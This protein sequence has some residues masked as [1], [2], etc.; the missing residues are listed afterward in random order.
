MNASV[1]LAA[2]VANII[3]T[4]WA[5][6]RTMKNQHKLDAFSSKLRW[7][8]VFF[9]CAIL[10]GALHFLGDGFWGLY[11]GMIGGMMGLVFLFLPNASFYLGKYLLSLKQRHR[12]PENL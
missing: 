9:G 2:A 12:S 11:V 1:T 6:H 5:V 3:L 10:F 8:V 7:T 4:V